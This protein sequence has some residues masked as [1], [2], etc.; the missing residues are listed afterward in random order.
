MACARPGAILTRPGILTCFARSCPLYAARLGELDSLDFPGLLL[1]LRG[2]AQDTPELQAWFQHVLV[3]EYQDTN[4]V[5]DEILSL[6]AS[7]WNNPTVVGDIG[8]AV[9]GWR[10]PS[11]RT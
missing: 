4:P 10:G 2:L 8:Q 5:Q 7:E 6:L 9:H 1:A 3:D 11:P